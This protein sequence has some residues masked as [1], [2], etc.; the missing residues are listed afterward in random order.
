MFDSYIHIHREI[1]REGERARRTGRKRESGYG[2]KKDRESNTN[3]KDAAH[4][5]YMKHELEMQ[6]KNWTELD[7]R[8]EWTLQCV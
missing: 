5:L 7:S 6:K 4:S 3:D 2:E 8:P 1:D